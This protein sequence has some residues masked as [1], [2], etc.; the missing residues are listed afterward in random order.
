MDKVEP[1]V[2]IEYL[3]DKKKERGF[4]IVKSWIET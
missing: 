1:D 3:E 2:Y 4:E